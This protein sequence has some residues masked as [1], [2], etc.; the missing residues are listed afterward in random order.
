MHLTP[1]DTRSDAKRNSN[2][3]GGGEYLGTSSMPTV[4]E[5]L[6]AQRNNRYFYTLVTWQTVN[7][8]FHAC[9]AE[10]VPPFCFG[11]HLRTCCQAAEFPKS[12]FCDAK[13]S[14]K[15]LFNI[16]NKN[17]LSRHFTIKL[18]FFAF[19]QSIN[20][21]IGGGWIKSMEQKV[22]RL[23]FPPH[24]KAGKDLLNSVSAAARHCV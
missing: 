21:V 3:L 4:A 18:V 24:G 16:C 20:G 2:P 7:L 6:H 13:T 1:F 5:I 19:K 23:F 10:R 15:R 14:H 12:F 11:G 9:R 17:K 22:S 8:F